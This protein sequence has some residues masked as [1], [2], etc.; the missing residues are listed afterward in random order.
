MNGLK[1]RPHKHGEIT[2]CQVEHHVRTKFA[3]PI[4]YVID[5]FKIYDYFS[6]YT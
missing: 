1:G 5:N 4:L 3:N 6:T 2:P